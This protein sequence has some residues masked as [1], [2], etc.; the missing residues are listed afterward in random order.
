[1]EKCRIKAISEGYTATLPMKIKASTIGP[2]TNVVNTIGSKAKIIDVTWKVNYCNYTYMIMFY[3]LFE[4]LAFTIDVLINGAV[5]TKICKFLPDTFKASLNN[6]WVITA[7][8]EV[9]DG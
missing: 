8:L 5:E 2:K 9:I 7:T 6:M 3:L 4:N 1:M